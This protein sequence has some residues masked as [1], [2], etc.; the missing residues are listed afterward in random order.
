MSQFGGMVRVERDA[1][2]N[3]RTTYEEIEVGAELGEIEWSVTREQVDGLI[4]ND[5]DYHEWYEKESPFGPPVV[6][7][8]ATYPPVR[9]LLTKKY[10]V[11]GLFFHYQSEF[12][13]PI[14]YGEVLKITGRVIDKW[15]KR[16]REYFQY[17]AVARDTEGRLV[18]RTQ[19]AHALDYIPRTAPRAGVGL[20]SGAPAP[21]TAETH[22]NGDST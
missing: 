5:F 8:M 20:D 6:P 21:R 4:E 13:R 16:D 15:I 12:F 17:E 19:R 22:A 11:R 18:F 1:T 9:I 3:R 10:N 2:G 14:F 7:P